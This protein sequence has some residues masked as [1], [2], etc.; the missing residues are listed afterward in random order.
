MALTDYSSM[1]TEIKNIPEPI[2][3]KKG[4]EVKAR[5]ISVKTGVIDK[6]GSDYEGFSYFSVSYDVPDEPL[7]KEFNDFFWGL[8]NRARMSEKDFLRA[9]RKFRSFAESFGLD[10]SRPFDLEDEL[11]G[12]EGWLIVGVKHSDEYGDQNTVSKYIN[13]PVAAPDSGDLPDG[14]PF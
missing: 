7:S 14:A 12:N 10:Y 13:A 2:T 1:E 3:I 6:P 11:P 5:I 9:V 8:E 4:T